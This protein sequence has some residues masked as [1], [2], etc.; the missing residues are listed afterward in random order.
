VSRAAVSYAERLTVP[1]WGWPLAAGAGVFA[2]AELVLGAPGLRHP[3]TF[4]VA[5]L[6]G[7]A[8]AAALSRIRIEVDGGPGGSCA[9]TT[10]GYRWT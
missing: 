5:G 7:L 9:W 4:T 10:P 2:A 1:W 8:G 3:V 6:L